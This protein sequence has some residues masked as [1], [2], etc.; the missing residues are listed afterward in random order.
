MYIAVCISPLIAIHPK[1]VCH[2]GLLISFACKTG[3]VSRKE[4]QHDGILQLLFGC[5]K[6]VED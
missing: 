2:C 3:S 4:E 5:G 1:K 6:G